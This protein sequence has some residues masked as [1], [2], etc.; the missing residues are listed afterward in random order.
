MMMIDTRFVHMNEVTSVYSTCIQLTKKKPI[1]FDVPLYRPSL[2]PT[3]PTYGCYTCMTGLH[4]S[5]LGFHILSGLGEHRIQIAHLFASHVAEE[6]S[7][8][9]K[10]GP[11]NICLLRQLICRGELHF[12]VACIPSLGSLNQAN[13][14]VRRWRHKGR[15]SPMANAPSPSEFN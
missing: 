8:S 9:P 4:R 10:C 11:W 12:N 7:A 5:H 6:G 3:I 13:M 14:V 2:M 15:K 1:P